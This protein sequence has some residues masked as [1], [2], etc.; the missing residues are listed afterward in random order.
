MRARLEKFEPTLASSGRGMPGAKPMVKVRELPGIFDI[1]KS[2]GRW[3]E[4]LKAGFDVRIERGRRVRYRSGD[5]RHSFPGL[6]M[7]GGFS[8]F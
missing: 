7:S 2:R 5:D 4:A 3:S 6:T 1:T 8:Y